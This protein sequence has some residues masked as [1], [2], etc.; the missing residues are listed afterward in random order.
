MFAAQVRAGFAGAQKPEL[1][2][3]IK[4]LRIEK[5]PFANLPMGKHGGWNEGVS[6][7]DMKKMIWVK[8]DVVVQ[9]A[10]VEWTNY[11]LLRHSSYLGIR[12]DKDP[13]EVI[14]EDAVKNPR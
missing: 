13:S 8:P 11:R 9:I 2:K 5:N 1:F 12:D 6:I 4:D 3:R 14:R 10:F 7:E